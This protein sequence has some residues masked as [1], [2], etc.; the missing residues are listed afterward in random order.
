MRSFSILPGLQ[1]AAALV[2]LSADTGSGGGASRSEGDAAAEKAAAEKA[3]AEKAAAEKAAAEKAAAEK[4]AAEKAA[5]EKAAAKASAKTAAKQA[6]SQ[7]GPAPSA[8]KVGEVVGLEPGADPNPPATAEAAVTEDG[9]A[10][11][12]WVMPGHEL[13][14]IG[15]LLKVPAYEAE[16]LRGAGR[17]RYAS[18]AEVEAGAVDAIELSGL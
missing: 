14:A 12:V 13:V 17:A 16:V 18:E 7:P 6:A 2:M 11:V 9:R 10:Y 5:A 4:A 8:P 1:T 3:A 15:A